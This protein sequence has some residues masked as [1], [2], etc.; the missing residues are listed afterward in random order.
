MG[1]GRAGTGCGWK[2]DRGC[3]WKMEGCDGMGME[4]NPAEYEW[5]IEIREPR[6][7]DNIYKK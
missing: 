3:G 4:N 5:K 6:G 7:D 1:V 2:I